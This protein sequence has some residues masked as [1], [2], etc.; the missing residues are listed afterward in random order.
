MRISVYIRIGLWRL[1]W[2]HVEH[3]SDMY[4]QGLP[5]DEIFALIGI[6]RPPSFT[7]VSPKTRKHINAHICGA[8]ARLGS[9]T[10]T[11][12]LHFHGASFGYTFHAMWRFYKHICESQACLRCVLEVAF[13]VV[14][15]VLL[16]LERLWRFMLVGRYALFD[17]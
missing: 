8:G 17:Q 6:A 5:R 9:F 3:H 10:H 12:H 4:L 13:V 7:I 2:K 11:R 15:S 16:N 14:V 1:P